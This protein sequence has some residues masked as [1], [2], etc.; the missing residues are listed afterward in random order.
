M[1]SQGNRDSGGFEHSFQ[2]FCVEYWGEKIYFIEKE[3][4][5][6]GAKGRPDVKLTLKKPNPNRHNPV[7]V[8]VQRDLYADNWLERTLEKYKNDCLIIIS[9]TKYEKFDRR[10]AQERI[11]TLLEADTKKDKVKNIRFF[12]KPPMKPDDSP[13]IPCKR[14]GKSKK[15][16]NL[17]DGL[18]NKCR[19]EQWRKNHEQYV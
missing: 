5:G 9:V 8:E 3:A 7:Y 4:K 18:C 15:Q 19:R 13:L 17:R 11:G 2:K 6:E 12:R 1:P 10:T 16:K 14:C